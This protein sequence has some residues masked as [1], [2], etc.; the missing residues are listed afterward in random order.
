MEIGLSD[1]Q[2]LF[3]ET[4]RRALD[5]RS[6]ISRV[7][8]LIDDPL[9][10]DR[11]FWAQGAELGWYS[12]LIPEE[13]GGGTVSGEGLVD[14]TIVAEE[15]G[16]AVHP[17]PF[18]T[19][20][21]VASA[22][23]EFGSPRQREEVLPKIAAGELI[24]SWAYAEPDRDWSASS[25][26]LTASPSGTGFVL[27]GVKAYVHDAEAADLLL[28]TALAPQGLT[29]FLV[30]RGAAGMTIEPLE[31]LDLARRMADVRFDGVSVAADGVVGEVGGAAPAV[32]R[33][34]QVALVL[35]CADSVGATD[36]GLA[37]TVQYSKDR[38]AFGRP[39]GS[40]Q[41][42]KHR[43]ADHRMWLEGSFATTAYAARAVDG[44]KRDAAISAR[45]AKAHVGKWSSAI[46][47]DC[48]QLHGGIGMTYEY[49]LHL[50]FRR[51]ISNEVL[52]GS[53]NEHYR[54]LVDLAE[55]AA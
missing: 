21:V 13:Y 11:A 37:L 41:A 10:F 15:L 40:Y 48:I 5:E 23:A 14:L 1:D 44:R 22:L 49:D 16:R 6:P 34:T 39:I 8:E 24:A 38:V 7:R 19:T 2:E 32:E 28:V 27:D 46:L 30:P 20:N 50:Y 25:V 55:G 4:T 36:Q 17:G 51:V 42:L 26:A 43:M 33:Q 18:H 45:I 47:H 53:P 35:Q 3:R 52:H 54:E 31:C 12:M 9:G 29:Q